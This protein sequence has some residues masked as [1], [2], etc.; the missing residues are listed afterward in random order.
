[1]GR[2]DD[3]IAILIGKGLFFL[4]YSLYKADDY[5]IR[6]VPILNAFSYRYM[7]L[8]DYVRALATQTI[9]PK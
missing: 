6:L 2:I 8:S 1:M 3:E 4:P 7:L 5:T 9:S